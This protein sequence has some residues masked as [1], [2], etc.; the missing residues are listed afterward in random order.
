MS[1][2]LMPGAKSKGDGEN[3][4]GNFN[5]VDLAPASD[6]R[7]R[8]IAQLEMKVAGRIGA[9][10]V[11]KYNNRQWKVQINLAGGIL[12]IACDSVSNTKGYHIHTRGRTIHELEKRAVAA[13][14]EILERHALSRD[15]LFNPDKLEGLIRD[16]FDNVITP[17]SKAEPINAK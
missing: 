4:T 3:I 5:E 13:A 14:G 12:I 15:K 17:D 7:E 11:R 2:I 8:R 9:L 1:G 10:L 16:Q 6:L